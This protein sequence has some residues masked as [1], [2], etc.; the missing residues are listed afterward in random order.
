MTTTVEQLIEW[1]RKLPSDTEVCV[2]TSS[3]N[4][5]WEGGDYVNVKDLELHEIPMNEYDPKLDTMFNDTFSFEQGWTYD[6]ENRVYA[7]VLTLGQ[8]G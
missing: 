7:P 5:G 4:S 2:L 3:T 6:K 1:L 8:K